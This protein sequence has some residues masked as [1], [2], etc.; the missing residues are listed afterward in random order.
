MSWWYEIAVSA[1]ALSSPTLSLN[2]PSSAPST[3]LPAEPAASAAAPWACCGVSTTTTSGPSVLSG[4]TAAP[5]RLTAEPGS[6]PA[7]SSRSAVVFVSDTSM[8]SSNMT[9][10]SRTSGCA[11]S[12]PETIAGASVSPITCS[13]F[14]TCAT[15]TPDMS[16]NDELPIQSCRTPSMPVAS[17]YCCCVS[18]RCTSLPSLVVVTW[19]SPSAT[20]TVSLEFWMRSCPCCVS[21]TSMGSSNPTTRTAEPAPVLSVA[22]V[23]S[24]LVASGAV[25][26]L[27][28]SVTLFGMPLWFSTAPGSSSR[29][30]GLFLTAHSRCASSSGTVTFL[31]ALSSASGPSASAR[32]VLVAV[33]RSTYFDPSTVL[34]STGTENTTFRVGLSL[35]RSS[36]TGSADSITGGFSLAILISRLSVAVF[37]ARSVAV[38][39]TVLSDPYS[40]NEVVSVLS[41]PRLVPWCVHSTRGS[42]VMLSVTSAVKVMS[43][44]IIYSGWAGSTI[45][46]MS[47]GT[48]SMIMSRLSAS[49]PSRFCGRA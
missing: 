14:T 23:T 18:L 45:I 43:S 15:P 19:A 42:S 17:L 7:S 49:D 26:M 29:R 13:V 1:A 8:A 40:P 5:A 37:P 6:L 36:R 10:I 32:D 28:L 33:L 48:A 38:T 3:I 39:T 21:E 25:V 9:R 35:S 16:E 34:E 27:A 44:L 4:C 22:F 47:G 11:L 24:G 12:M 41:V 2:A 30:S 31:P 20:T 46:L